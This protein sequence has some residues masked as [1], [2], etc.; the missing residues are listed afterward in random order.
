MQGD[1]PKRDA[2]GSASDHQLVWADIE[3]R[4]GSLAPHEAC[5]YAPRQAQQR[6]RPRR[7][8]EHGERPTNSAHEGQS[9]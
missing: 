1:Q 6:K 9:L 5:P 7:D 3:G 8:C 4:Y 2:G